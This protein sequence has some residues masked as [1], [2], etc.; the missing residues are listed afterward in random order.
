MIGLFNEYEV[1]E[2][3]FYC[4]S[5]LSPHLDLVREP[6][7]THPQLL[8]TLVSQGA[9]LNLSFLTHKTREIKN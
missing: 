5:Q 9:S 1:G 6:N 4:M 3:G 7:K 8:L 2:I